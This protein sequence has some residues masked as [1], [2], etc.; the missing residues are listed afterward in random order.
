[1]TPDTFLASAEIFSLTCKSRRSAQVKVL[2]SMGI[3][4][5]V[6]PDG[7]VAILRAHITKIFDGDPAS[8]KKQAKV[9]EPNWSAI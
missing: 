6:R 9:I 8:A 5:R 2:N 1:M 3:S 7:S 4:H